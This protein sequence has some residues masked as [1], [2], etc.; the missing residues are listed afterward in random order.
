LPPSCPRKLETDPPPSFFVVTVDAPTCPRTYQNFIPALHTP[1]KMKFLG[2]P[3]P[4]FVRPLPSSAHF[5]LLFFP[6]A[7]RPFAP[8][9][10]ILTFPFPPTLIEVLPSLDHAVH[11]VPYFLKVLLHLLPSPGSFS[12]IS[13]PCFSP[14]PDKGSDTLARLGLRKCFSSPPRRFFFL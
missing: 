7:V 8:S 4:K 9:F 11:D 13:L 14:L 10:L 2:A 5:R 3:Q 12:A 1:T 6:L